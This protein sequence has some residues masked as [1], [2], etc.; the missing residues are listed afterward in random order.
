MKPLVRIAIL[1][2]ALAPL[3]AAALTISDGTFQ[4]GDW[5]ALEILDTS[6]AATFTTSQ[7]LAGGN[8]GSFRQTTHSI[9]EAGQ[10]I[11]LAHVFSVASHDPSL[12]GGI[13]SIDFALE[14]RFI[15][16]SEGT[17]QVGYQLLL[18]QAGTHYNTLATAG[19]V[20]Q[21]P[22]QGLPGPWSSHSFPGLTA[23]SFTRVF[24]AGPASPDFSP[25]GSAIQFGYMTQNT[26]L[27]TAIATTS[28]IDDWSVTIIPGPAAS[29]LLGAAPACLAAARRGL[30]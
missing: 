11:I 29:A 19:A 14:L 15:G 21:G 2:L 24:G 27:E 18:V 30:V 26:A 20:A 6:G 1:S 13:A 3:R 23:T 7:Q 9:P 25:G 16:G 28:G 12:Q 4:D 10:S 5:S 8:P 17:S 22:G